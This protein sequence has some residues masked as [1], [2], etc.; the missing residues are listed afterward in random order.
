[1][2]LKIKRN[3]RIAAMT[4]IMCS[5]PCQ[6][7]NLNQFSELFNSGKST[8]CEDIAIIRDTLLALRL[9]DLESVAGAGGGVRFVPR[10]DKRNTEEYISELCKSLSDPDRI[11]PGGYIYMNDILHNPQQ[12]YKIGE[13]LAS[14]FMDVRPDFVI[15]VE[16]KGTPV[17]I[18]TA[19]SLGCPVVVAGRNGNVTEG[20]LVSINYVTASSRR[21]QTMSLSKRAVKE[22]SR[23]LIIDDFM[24]GGG[25]ARG[26]AQLLKEFNVDIVGTGVVIA[27]REP[28]VKLVSSYTSLIMLEQVDESERKIE[29]SPADWIKSI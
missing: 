11:L 21:I 2:L 17:A 5:H 20:P 10:V 19:F 29:L 22:G 25:T 13:I 18:M 24:K 16:T 1:M 12:I 26:M 4:R 3:E 6:I 14:R 23:A 8:I 27:T 28:Q 9:G 7:F 15:T